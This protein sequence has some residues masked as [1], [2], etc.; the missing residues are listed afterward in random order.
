MAKIYPTQQPDNN[1]N[2]QNKAEH[3]AGAA[4]AIPAVAVVATA[5]TENQYH[6]ENNEYQAHSFCF[7]LQARV[8]VL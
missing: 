6:Y 5:A 7:L 3:S 1:K 2:D 8:G 4:S